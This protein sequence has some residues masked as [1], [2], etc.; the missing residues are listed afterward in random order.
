MPISQ[1]PLST[2]SQTMMVHFFCIRGMPLF[3]VENFEVV[4]IDRVEGCFF[5]NAFSSPPRARFH[6]VS[7]SEKSL[8]RVERSEVVNRVD[9]GCVFC[10]HRLFTSSQSTR[11]NFLRICE[12]LLTSIDGGSMFCSRCLHFSSQSQDLLSHSREIR[13]RVSSKAQLYIQTATW[14]A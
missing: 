4:S 1:H 6:I 12:T 2:S 8:I 9:G 14:W 3:S 10:S 7:A 11:L 5:P 13:G